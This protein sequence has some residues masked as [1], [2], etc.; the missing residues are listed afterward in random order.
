ML[1]WQLRVALHK[2][3]LDAATN[4]LTGQGNRRAL[5]ELLKQQAELYIS[6]G[7]PFSILMLDIDFFKKYQ[8]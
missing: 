6:S 5:D 4:A 2:V 7:K 8:R 1:Y 3:E